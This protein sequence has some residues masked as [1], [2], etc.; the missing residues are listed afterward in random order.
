MNRNNLI[1]LIFFCLITTSFANSCSTLVLAKWEEKE[2]LSNP[3]FDKEIFLG[4]LISVNEDYY[5]FQ[6]LESSKGTLEN[7]EQIKGFD[8]INFNDYG[9]EMRHRIHK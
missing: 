7:G 2:I 4:K 8:H 9:K 6:I 3:G 1:A 5:E